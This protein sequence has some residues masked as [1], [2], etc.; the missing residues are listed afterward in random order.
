MK[1]LLNRIWNMTNKQ[2]TIFIIV[3]TALCWM[4]FFMIVCKG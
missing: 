4:S 3:C 2:E 1:K